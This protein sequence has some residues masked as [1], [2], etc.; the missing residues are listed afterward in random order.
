MLPNIFEELLLN[1]FCIIN[2][3]S[4]FIHLEKYKFTWIK[5]QSE[6]HY[7]ETVLDSNLMNALE[8]THKLVGEKY[9]QSVGDYTITTN[10]IWN[11]I[12][13]DTLY[14]HNDLLFG[15]NIAALLYFNTLTKLTGGELGIRNNSTHEEV[16]V[17]P[18]Q[19]DIIILNQDLI[20]EHKANQLKMNVPRIVAHFDFYIPLF[21]NQQI[22]N[23][24]SIDNYSR[25][26]E[27]LYRLSTMKAFY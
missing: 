19:Y 10:S 2:D 18:T 22:I 9:F 12:D 8:L 1:G 24:L 15:S 26:C 25:Q 20:W 3:A 7:F 13:E 5:N 16:V 27:K 21:C 14:W 4:A 17:Y 23:Y 11:G 6:T